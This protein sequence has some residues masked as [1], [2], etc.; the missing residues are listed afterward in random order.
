M[1]SINSDISE[2][3]TLSSME[4]R[5]YMQLLIFN[6]PKTLSLGVDYQITPDS[7]VLYLKEIIAG[8]L[9]LSVE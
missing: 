1:D 6:T 8:R 2:I 4:E 9:G 5:D 3:S 7:T